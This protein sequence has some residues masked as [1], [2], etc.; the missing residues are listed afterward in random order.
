MLR[1]TDEILS[2]Q[3]PVRLAAFSFLIVAVVGAI[4]YLTG[5]ELS[6]SIF[7]LLPVGFA[8]WYLRGRFGFVIGLVSAATWLGADYTSGHQYSH[9]AIPI[10]NA[11]VRLGFFIIV[12]VLLKRFKSALEFQA[13]LAQI[14]GLTGLMNSRTFKQRC[15]SLFELA[16]RNGHPL[17]LGFVDL[18][19]FKVVNDRFG[20]SV[21]DQVL[22]A[23]AATLTKRLRGSDICARLGGDE[24][25]VLLPET[26][27]SGARTFFTGL[28]ESL[29]ELAALNHWPV[30]FS[31]GV[32]V[33]HS[34]EASIDEAIQCADALM[35]RVKSSGKN[36]VLFEEHGNVLT[37]HSRGTRLNGP[38]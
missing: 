13:S 36:R 18:D 2:A 25:S 8:A 16:S 12:A 15:S 5:Y 24:F 26:D 1:E 34:P 33:F 37:S 38:P 6:F 35:Y 14:D 23:V 17:A 10:W 19:N 27:L 32:A 9:L 3:S 7:Y 20:H 22:T 4:D 28:H 31:I 30:G 29:L 11:G 21:G